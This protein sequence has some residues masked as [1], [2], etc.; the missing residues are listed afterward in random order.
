MIKIRLKPIKVALISYNLAGGGAERNLINLANNFPK[1][2][3]ADVIVFKD[4]NNYSHLTKRLTIVS[5]LK[6]NEKVNSLTM[7]FYLSLV[8]FRAIKTFISGKYQV[9]VGTVEGWPYYIA[10]IT[11]R[12]LGKKS[13]LV[14]GNNLT[15]EYR[16]KWFTRLLIKVSLQQT[17]YI[18]SVSQGVKQDLITRFGIKK[19]KISTIP[20]G[21]DLSSISKNK[22]QW[23]KY[24]FAIITAGRLVTRKGHDQLIEAF[25]RLVKLYP[26]IQLQI[27]GQGPQLTY[28]QEKVAQLKITSQV[29]FL[30]FQTNPINF[31]KKASIF[32]LPSRYEGFAN[33]LIEALACGVAVI[34]SDCPYGPREILTGKKSRYKPVRQITFSRYGILVPPVFPPIKKGQLTIC[35]YLVQGISQLFTQPKRLLYYQQIGLQRAQDYSLDKMVKAYTRLISQMVK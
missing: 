15:A 11:A 24:Q 3:N 19:E 31:F 1:T 25:A 29:H 7:V 14:V 9:Y 13:L 20:N 22:R 23:K 33:V 17:D 6:K 26:K 5:L 32:V 18:I 16:S 12:L 8:F 28:L 30:G 10:V 2:I 27:L 4:I 21:V 35:D 34:S